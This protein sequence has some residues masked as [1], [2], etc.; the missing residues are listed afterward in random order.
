[1]SKQAIAHAAA[2]DLLRCD[3]LAREL[4]VSRETIRRWTKSE[5]IP[6]L[7]LGVGFVRYD[8]AKVLAS[9]EP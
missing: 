6:Y 1:M 3:E 4:K 2:R 7:R 8:R 5:K 9:L